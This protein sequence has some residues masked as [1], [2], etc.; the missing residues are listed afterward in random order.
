MTLNADSTILSGGVLTGAG[1]ISGP[2]EL[3][4]AG[5]I[6]PSGGLLDIDT[7]AFANLGTVLINS[8]SLTIEN[9]VTD[10]DL[11]GG[12]LTGG[13]WLLEWGDLRVLAG[14]ITTLDTGLTVSGTATMEDLM[15]GT[16]QPVE[17]SLSIVGTA[18]SWI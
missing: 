18:G 10:N 5:E 2:F 12:T 16:V 1:T 4:N 9:S 7:G 13:T 15:G 8:G 3:L 17:N 14:S 11:S 6:I